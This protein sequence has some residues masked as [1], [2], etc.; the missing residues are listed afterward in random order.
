MNMKANNE[1]PEEDSIDVELNVLD[2]GDFF[3][4]KRG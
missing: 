1:L 2:N 3:G 4:Q